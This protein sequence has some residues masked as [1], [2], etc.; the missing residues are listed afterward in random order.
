MSVDLPKFP[1][2][3][4]KYQLSNEKLTVMAIIRNGKIIDAAP[5]IRVFIGQPLDNLAAW[6]RKL[7]PT[8][9]VLLS[10]SNDT[11]KERDPYA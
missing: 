2:I 7:G 6:M 8:E 1:A 10:T 9:L 11:Q 5:V 4:C 3:I